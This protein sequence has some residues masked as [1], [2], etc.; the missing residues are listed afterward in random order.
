MK[1][2][3]TACKPGE[4]TIEFLRRTAQVLRM[5][6]HPHRLKIVEILEGCDEGVPVHEITARL[7]L[8][9]AS[10]SQHLNQMRRVGLVDCDRRGRE[11]R[12]RIADDRSLSILDCIR[13][14]RTPA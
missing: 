9:Q 2:T 7:G 6:A 8:P 3:N 10:T 13:K 5:L 14:R 11:V 1:T 4:L 12:Y